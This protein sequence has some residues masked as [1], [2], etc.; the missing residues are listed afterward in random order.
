MSDTA[1]SANVRTPRVETVVIALICVIVAAAGWYLLSNQQQGLRRS[2]AGLDGLQVWLSTNGISAQNFSGGW[3]MDQ[4]S[5]GLLV[6]PV[7]DTALDQERNRPTTKEQLLQQQ[8]EYDLELENIAEKAERVPTL[9]VLPKWRSG[10][11]LT[12]L[13][14]PTLRVESDGLAETL[15][16][17]TDDADAQIAFD[18]APFTEFSYRSSD[19]EDL[20]A[21]IYAPQT[22]VNGDCTSVIG[23]EDGM[24][25]A[26]CPLN[27]AGDDA[28]Q[29]SVLILSDPDL[30]NNHGLR[31]ADNATI[32]LDVLGSR[33][34]DRNIVIDYSRTS[35]LRDPEAE[36]ERE[37]TWADLLRFFEQPFLTLWIGSAA[38]FALFLWRASLRYGPVLADPAK[39]GASK[40]LAVRARARLM[41][42]SGQDGALTGEYAAARVAATAETLFGA[43]HARHFMREDDFLKYVKR[44]HPDHAARL[45]AALT[46]IRNLPAHL[47]AADAIHIIDELEQVLEQ[48][49]HDA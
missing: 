19:G 12:G 3:L 16:E 23:N 25:L 29:D 7:Y 28:E 14:H 42:L 36:P 1:S 30:L 34:D 21:K 37:R 40:A 47:P 38:L 15:G 18:S 35:W 22:F 11:R 31:L 32:A 46:N 8:D 10:M 43:A 41:R 33:A 4:T 27:T 49:T 13:A 2:P 26:E 44:R 24:L 6:V 45:E 20:W 5:I 48:I 39:P 9:V 17:L